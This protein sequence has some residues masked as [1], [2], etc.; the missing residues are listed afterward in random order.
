MLM[1]LAEVL[2]KTNWVQVGFVTPREDATEHLS[3]H[4]VRVGAQVL[5]QVTPG[6]KRL[7]TVVAFEGLFTRVHFLM[8]S[9][10]RDLRE[11]LAAPWFFA[12]IRLEVIVNSLMLI[13]R[14]HLDKSLLADLASEL[15]IHFVSSFVF[16]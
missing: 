7:V 4:L 16:I 15:S 1:M 9:E 3:C 10:V 13:Q 5:L 14:R 12:G 2:L 11:R 6:A 8:S